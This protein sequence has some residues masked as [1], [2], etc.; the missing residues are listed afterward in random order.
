MSV[1]RSTDTGSVL[2]EG[3]AYAVSGTEIGYTHTEIVS[4]TEIG[5][6]GRRR[7][8]SR[9][10]PL[11]PYAPLCYLP[12]HQSATYLPQRAVLTWRML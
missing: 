12:T 1:P 10:R 6:G 3:T 5:H 9:S 11:P 8:H 4:G 7:P 2:R